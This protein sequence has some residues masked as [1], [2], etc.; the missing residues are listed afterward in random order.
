M[1]FV[2]FCLRKIKFHKVH[3]SN[4]LNVFIY[5]LTKAAVRITPQ[6]NTGACNEENKR[7]DEVYEG[8]TPVILN[9]GIRSIFVVNFT[10]WLLHPPENKKKHA[11]I[12]REE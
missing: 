6:V 2:P 7:A 3:Y 12:E 11:F 8:V 1:T 9:L 5:K 4:E 10:A